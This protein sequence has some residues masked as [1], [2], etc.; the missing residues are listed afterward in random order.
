[1]TSPFPIY[2]LSNLFAALEV[3][4]LNNPGKLSIARGIAAF[5]S[6]FFS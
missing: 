1:M 2:F 3:K 6:D 5:A 4:L